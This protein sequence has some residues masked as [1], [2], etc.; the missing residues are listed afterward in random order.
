MSPKPAAKPLRGRPPLEVKRDHTI[1]VRVKPDEHEAAL[2]VAQTDEVSISRI[3][4]IAL[5]QYLR[6]RGALAAPA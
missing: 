5:R 2:V 4:Q 1:A 6:K 3:V